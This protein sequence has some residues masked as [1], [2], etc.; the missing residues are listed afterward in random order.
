MEVYNPTANTWT[1]LASL[2][3]TLY[4]ESAVSD[5]AGHIFTF[6]GVGANGT[7]TNIVYRYTIAT[8]TWDQLASPMQVGV[9]DS[10][11]VL[12]PNG[13]IY[14]LGGQAAAGT[15]ATVESYNIAANTWNLETSL[16]QPVR[17]A[18][19]AVD[20]LGRIEVLGGYDVNG[21]ATASISVSQELTQPDLAPTITSSPVKAALVNLPYSYQVLSTGNP[22]P[23]YVLSSGPAGMTIDPNTGLITWTPT[24][25]TEGIATVTVVASSSLGQVSQTYSV[26]VA[27]QTPTGLTGVGTSTTSIT[28]SWNASTDPNVTG[29]NVYLRT[30]VHS[31]RGSGGSYY[32]SL[33]AADVASNS[34]TISGTRGGSYLISAVNS[35]GVESVR[36]AVVSVAA[37]SPPD[38]YVA[39]TTSGAD[40]SSLTLSVGQTGQ[41]YLIQEFANPAP[42]FSLVNG[43][44]GITVDPTTGLVTYTPGPTDIGQQIV[45][46]AATNSAG[47]S[48][49]QFVYDVLALNPTV[50]VAGEQI[51]YDGN[52]HGASASALGVDGVTAVAGNF[53]FTYNGNATAPTAAGTYTVQAT[54]TSADPSYASSVATGTLTIGP[55]TPTVTLSGGQFNFDGNPHGATATEVGVDGVTPVAGSFQI[56]YNGD[57]TVPSAPGFY[58][59]VAAF[60]S[61]DPNYAS[62]TATSSSDHQ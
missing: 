40:I 37:Q 24:F 44:N 4:G 17:S 9:R 43:P 19:A 16:P 6:G 57:P 10:A 42:T 2:P 22:Q 23:T 27:P 56:T 35:S 30:F 46:F 11:A 62:T 1:Y 55:A 34:V 15:T 31:P 13:L 49:Y 20:S 39:T 52:P 25:A 28:L 51:T 58:T 5:G 36:S 61:N 14:V 38:L 8:N 53:S 48:T 32:Y 54:F 50:T 47:T 41:I 26:A 45:T 29:Y 18:A 3:Q 12:A 21:N 33:V 60:A 59:V 7:I